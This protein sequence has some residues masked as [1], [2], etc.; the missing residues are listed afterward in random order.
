MPGP[1]VQPQY[2]P[3]LPEVVGRGGRRRLPLVAALVVAVAVG[4]VLASRGGTDEREQVRR[5]PVAFNLR[6]PPAL[7][8]LT[9]RPGEQL[10]LEQRR[11]ALFLASFTVRR[12]ALPPYAGAVGGALPVLAERYVRAAAR[13]HP[14]FA[15]V[16][17]GR[18]RINDVPGYGF[19]FRARL[20]DRRLY[21]R[22]VLLPLPDEPRTRDGVVLE[23]LGTPA[24][25]V[26]R[27]EQAGS[28]GPAK[29]ALRS[30]RF[31]TEPP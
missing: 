31:G 12:L 17:E 7:K 3:T 5:E 11:G 26:G 20:G 16:E 21:G 4:I 13:R 23:V 30:F 27:A 29:T 22:V 2:G 10:R 25:G 15:L 1:V 18:A 14:G 8:E 24:G 19:V 6:H 9:P 28:A